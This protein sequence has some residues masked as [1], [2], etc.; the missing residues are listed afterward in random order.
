MAIS[1]QI[2]LDIYFYY[3]WCRA[4]MV[5]L[6]PPCSLKRSLNAAAFNDISVN[7]KGR[8]RPVSTWRCPCA[9]EKNGFSQFGAAWTELWPQPHAAPLRW[10]GTLSGRLWICDRPL[11]NALE[12]E[13]EQ[14]P[15]ARLRNLEESLRPENWRLLWQWA[16]Q[17]HDFDFRTR[18][19][20]IPYRCDVGVSNYF[21]PHNV[22]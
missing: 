7:K 6:R 2:P 14:I 22:K 9:W 21:W 8:T 5:W 19:S 3:F 1:M 11:Y 18:C 13:W 4:V 12:A 16:A 10:T 20:E 15:A 17:G